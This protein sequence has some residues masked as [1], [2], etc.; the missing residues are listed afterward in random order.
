VRLFLDANVL[1]TAAHNPRGKARLVIE[2]GIRGYWRLYSSR[3]TLEEARR[4]LERKF[5]VALAELGTFQRSIRLV[6]H[7]AD[8]ILP[9]SL[10][11][12]DRPVFQAALACQATLLLTGDMNEFG[13]V[14]NQPEDTSGICIET[15]AEFLRQPG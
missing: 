10:S 8:F 9:E 14:M 3:Y 6:E 13:P 1:F 5:P 4:N 15:V 7:R 12:K 2:L 11:Q